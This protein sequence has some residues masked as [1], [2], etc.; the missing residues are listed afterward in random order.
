MTAGAPFHGGCACGRVR[1]RLAEPP[2]DTGYCHCRLCQRTTGA[3]VL[4]YAVVPRD[5]CRWTAAEPETYASSEYG[6]RRFC[7]NCG[8]QVA[9]EDVREAWLSINSA[10]LDDPAPVAPR[11]HIWTSSRIPWFDVRDDLPRC[12][13]GTLPSP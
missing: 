10:A 8:T 2:V 5:S 7:A 13:G 12:A 4:A 1:F 11:A 3:P 6:R 9:Y